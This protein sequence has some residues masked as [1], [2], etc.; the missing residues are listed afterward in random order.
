VRLTSLGIHPHFARYEIEKI[1]HEAGYDSLLTAQIFIKLSAQLGSGSQVR[2][3]GSLSNI[4]LMATQHGLNNRFSHL[5]V[6]ETS[7]G[8]AS[9]FVVE[10]SERNDG[11][12]GEQSHAEEIRLAEK[13]LLIPRPNFQFWRVYGNNL[14][15]FGTKE[16]VCR[17]GENAA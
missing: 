1:D 17:I 11:V 4:S 12:L 8:L 2:S 16:R 3:A 7:N 6:E 9:P 13:G 10:E 15:V 5:Q 14:R